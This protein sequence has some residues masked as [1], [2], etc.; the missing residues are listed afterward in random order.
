MIRKDRKVVPIEAK[1]GKTFAIKSL[2]NFKSKFTN[3]VGMQYVLYDGDIKLDGEII[4]LPYYVA[5]IL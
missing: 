4:Y 5:S 1:S 3:R 2:Q